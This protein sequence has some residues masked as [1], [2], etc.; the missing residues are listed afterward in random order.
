MN[1][2]AK[3]WE[4]RPPQPRAESWGNQEGESCQSKFHHQVSESRVSR[5]H[6]LAGTSPSAG[7]MGW[8]AQWQSRADFLI[9]CN[10][11]LI[12]G[13]KNRI[14]ALDKSNSDIGQRVR[15]RDQVKRLAQMGPGR[16]HVSLALFLQPLAQHLALS[17][18]S[19][20]GWS[21]E[22][23]GFRNQ[24]VSQSILAEVEFSE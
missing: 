18:L 12:L 13:Q 6:Q 11:L 15:G 9:L 1:G 20:A 22:D 2:D 19:L 14:S 8:V 24:A 16:S 21:S 3:S 7:S 5:P 17:E 4:A 23:Q 10:I